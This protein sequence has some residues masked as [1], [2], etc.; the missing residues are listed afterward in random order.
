MEKADASKEIRWPDGS[1]YQ[2]NPEKDFKG[3]EGAG[4][5]STVIPFEK[6]APLSQDPQTVKTGDQ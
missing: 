3:K 5:Q 4:A 2:P 1:P 6:I